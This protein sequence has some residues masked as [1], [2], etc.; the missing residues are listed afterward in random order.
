M[1]AAATG[2]LEVVNQLG[3][4]VEGRAIYTVS[5]KTELDP[6]RRLTL[7]GVCGR[8]FKGVAWCALDA[9]EAFVVAFQRRCPP[10]ER[11]GGIWDCYGTNPWPAEGRKFPP[12]IEQAESGKTSVTLEDIYTT[13]YPLRIT[14]TCPECGAEYVTKNTT[15]LRLFLDAVA[16][17]ETRITLT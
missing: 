13:G 3:G 1:Q 6:L 11:V 12:W 2:A 9:G 10:R 16:H 4:E 15:R 5:L 14:F 17:G 7:G 8:C